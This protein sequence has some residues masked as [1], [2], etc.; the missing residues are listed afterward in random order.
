MG[1]ANI[2]EQ[3][4]SKPV[5]VTW[6]ITHES[7]LNEIWWRNHLLS[8]AR[9][10]VRCNKMLYRRSQSRMSTSYIIQFYEVQE[11][12]KFMYGDRY[13]FSGLSLERVL[14]GRVKRKPFGVL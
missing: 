4:V 6:F 10:K 12:V 11:Q 7:L 2:P 3:T 14:T 13:Q 8:N 9:L 5:P 1:I